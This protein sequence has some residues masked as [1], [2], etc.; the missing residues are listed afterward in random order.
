VDT[1]ILATITV[2]A[3]GT[4]LAPSEKV[5]LPNPQA[6]I[7]Y[8]AL[9]NLVLASVA[10]FVTGPSRLTADLF[11]Y[12]FIGGVIWSIA[13][14]MAFTATSRIG[15]AKAMGTWAPLNILVGIFWG[16]LLFGEFLQEG[17]HT[18]LFAGAA[19]AAIVAGILFIIFS[20]QDDQSAHIGT[21]RMAGFGG[22]LGAGILWGSYFVP[23][24]WLA[25][26]VDGVDDWVVAF[27]LAVGMFAGS[28][29]LV[30]IGRKAPRCERK[31]DTARLL[32]S[33]VLWTVGNFSMLLLVARIGIGKGFTIAQMCVVMNALVGI[34]VFRE[35]PPRSS[36]AR[37][38]LVGILIAT[39]GAIV[40]GNLK[41]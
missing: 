10:L 38:T 41:Y 12:P 30:A 28:L 13:G 37:R 31:S 5:R 36:A 17:P 20:G 6:R 27:P 16:M 25:R 14:W 26:T 21:G 22:A 23:T 4:W 15:M 34:L 24:A 40:L 11:L 33:G 3:W 7:F 8:V 2:L 18:I 1:L 32:A 19:V 9:G 29:V 39:T 35:P